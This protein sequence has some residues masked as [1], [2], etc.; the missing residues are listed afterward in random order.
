[1]KQFPRQELAL[2]ELQARRVQLSSH[3]QVSSLALTI[4]QSAG[5][6]NGMKGSGVRIVIQVFL[7]VEI[8]DKVELLV[9]E[10]KELGIS[11]GFVNQTLDDKC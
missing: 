7:L 4:N 3:I 11:A 5:S 6:E 2:E 8:L 1:M 9:K 10:V